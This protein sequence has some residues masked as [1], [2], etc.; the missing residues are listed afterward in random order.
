VG[1][2][3]IDEQVELALESLAHDLHVQQTEEAATEAE[4]QCVRNSPART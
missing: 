2:V 4:A 1:A 3:A